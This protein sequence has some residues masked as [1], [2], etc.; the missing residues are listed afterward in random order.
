MFYEGLVEKGNLKVKFSGVVFSLISITTLAY[1]VLV[2]CVFISYSSN[3]SKLLLSAWNILKIAESISLVLMFI[4]QIWKC[5][6]VKT[7]LKGIDEVDEIVRIHFKRIKKSQTIFQLFNPQF[8]SLHIKVDYKKHSK[9]SWIA[10][11]LVISTATL[12]TCLSPIMV[13]GSYKSPISIRTTFRFF[14]GHFM[15]LFYISQFILASFAV[16]KRFELLN[17]SLETCGKNLQID[18]LKFLNVFHKLCDGIEVVNDSFTFNLVFVF[19]YIMVRFFL[20]AKLIKLWFYLKLAEIFGAFGII[21]QLITNDSFAYTYSIMTVIFMVYYKIVIIVT[22]CAS[23]K[24]TETA[25]NTSK[26]L[27]QI[28]SQTQLTEIQ[29]INFVFMTKQIE[30]RNLKFRNKMFTIDWNVL[31]TVKTW[32]NCWNY[33]E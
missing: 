9:T 31:I 24:A 26:V 22:I 27:H 11:F 33:I 25:S 6:N 30:S 32:K 10:V 15:K 13:S 4:Y 8:K 18:E 19:G 1:L 2:N 21:K 16:G 14:Y 12:I 5:K 7:F 29:K 3:E 17:K 28:T 20:V 23:N